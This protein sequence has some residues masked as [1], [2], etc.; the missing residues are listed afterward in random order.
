M[1]ARGFEKIGLE[2]FKNDFNELDVNYEDLILPR[3]STKVSAGYDFFAPFDFILKPNDIIKIPSG[4]KVYMQ[5]DEYLA[6]FVRGSVGFK[7]NV[8]LCNQTGIIDADYYNN[9]SNEGH[10]FI[11]L[12]NEG[13]KD[14]IIKKGDK[15]VQGIFCKYLLVD[16]DNAID[17][18]RAGGFGSTN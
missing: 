10:I 1:K 8:R 9:P 5:N 4:I 2:Q 3:R 6:I 11:A 14:W 16:N 12:K 15:I 17:K 7:Y 18:E 13:D